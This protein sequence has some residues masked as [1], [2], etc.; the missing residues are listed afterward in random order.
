MTRD[1]TGPVRFALAPMSRSILVLTAALLAI[2][3]LF[4]G[5]GLGAG[6]P[7]R[8]LF[9]VVGSATAA[10]YGAVWIWWRPS[11]FEV[12]GAGLRIC[13]PGRARLV[14]ASDLAAA[15]TLTGRAFRDEY[16]LALRIGVGGLWGGFGWLWTRRRGLVEFYVSRLDGFVLLERRKGRPILFTPVDPEEVA[17]GVAEVSKRTATSPF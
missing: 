5:V 1:A 2:P 14:P 16:G 4:V 15:R 13:F 6:P 12:S 11:R 9:L 8:A 10:L 7:Q 17:R 3:V